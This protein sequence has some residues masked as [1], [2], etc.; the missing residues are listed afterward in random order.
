ML[1]LFFIDP[2]TTEIYTLSLH[3]ALPFSGC[4]V[5]DVVS[6]GWDTVYVT[7]GDELV[8]FDS[9]GFVQDTWGAGVL[10]T[11]EGLALD[12]SGNVYIADPDAGKV[13]SYSPQGTLR[14]QLA[15]VAR[16][17]ALDR[18]GDL[19]AACAD[20]YLRRYSK[21]PAP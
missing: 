12:A 13:F 16:D 21:L 4:E 6:D 8:V 17:V 3:D 20:N 10:S 15:V 5:W 11:A 9:F 1:C 7:A 19:I 14:T 2:T 18:N